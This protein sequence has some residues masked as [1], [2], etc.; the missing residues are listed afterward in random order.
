MR[1][2]CLLIPDLPLR[3]ELRAYESLAGQPVAIA[4]G[5]DADARIV[6]ASPEALGAGVFP[7]A[8]IPR[9]RSHCPRLQLR[10]A[11]PRLER[12]ARSALVD[13]ALSFSPRVALAPRGQGPWMSEA[14]IHLDASGIH[15]LF[16]S[17]SGF[18]IELEERA[19]QL[20]LPGI[21][22]VAGSRD[23]AHLL[24][25]T[26]SRNRDNPRVLA[27]GD[28]AD[29]LAPLP[30]D[31]L[32]PGEPLGSRLSRFGIHRVRDLLAL[33]R[34]GLAKRLGPQ[35]RALLKRV[36]GENEELPLPLWHDP[37]V[38]ESIDLEHP[39][40]QVEPL[41]FILRGLLS[42]L[43]ERLR[44][45]GR[46]AGPLDLQLRLADGSREERRIGLAAPTDDVRVLLRLLSL[47]LEN[48][49]PLAPIESLGLAT[50]GQEKRG[51]QLD[52]FQPRGPDPAGLDRTLAELETLC[53]AGRVGAPETLDDH[54]PDRFGLRPFSHS[55]RSPGSL[56]A[57]PAP[58]SPRPERSGALRAL[59][60][61]VHAEVR[62]ERGR[63]HFLRCAVASGSLVEVA[64]PWRISGHWWNDHERFAFDYFDI[65]VE[66]TS[67]LRLRFDWIL[68]RWQVDG[69]YD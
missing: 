43:L 61:P 3:A 63:P 18:A 17:E 23:I 42:R 41:L 30:V 68:K 44:L 24:A 32:E 60:P 6:S 56:D 9:A 11:S 2:A 34:S 57:S 1:I 62:V 8:S 15:A 69:I 4:S 27:P 67:L 12:T 31:W 29:F 25:R 52:L 40:A 5:T 13:L 48:R 55:P 45:R 16:R 14:A 38:E 53:G 36:R 35:G 65:Q 58:D 49:P 54:R 10:V 28:E 51:N 46:V 26:L 33:P 59:R 22:A 37:R 64:G 19:S 66:D 47:G 20:G 7:G 50:E 39:V 21:A